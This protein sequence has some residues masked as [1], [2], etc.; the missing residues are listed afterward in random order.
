MLFTYTFTQA[1]VFLIVPIAYCSALA[2]TV[3]TAAVSFDLFGFKCVLLF[4]GRLGGQS[5]GDVF[6]DLVHAHVLLRRHLVIL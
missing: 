3:A 6:E 1:V 5:L 4:I 2:G